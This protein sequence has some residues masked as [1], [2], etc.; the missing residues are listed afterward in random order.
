MR[1]Q[2]PFFFLA[3]PSFCSALSMSVILFS[4]LSHPIVMCDCFAR[5]H[6]TFPKNG[7]EEKNRFPYTSRAT[8][9]SFFGNTK[10]KP[11]FPAELSCH[12]R[13]SIDINTHPQNTIAFRKKKKNYV[14]NVPLLARDHNPARVFTQHLLTALFPTAGLAFDSTLYTLRHHITWEE[15]AATV[16]LLPTTPPIKQTNQLYTFV[17]ATTLL[18]ST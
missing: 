7:V 9:S 10:N 3:S 18:L 8:V 17:A 2:S 14:I 1:R 11:I 15:T 13:R 6:V 5:V 16:Y 4:V 12:S